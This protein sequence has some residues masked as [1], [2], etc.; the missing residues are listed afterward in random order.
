MAR[1]PLDTAQPTYGKTVGRAVIK[2]FIHDYLHS[3]E[4]GFR[5]MYTQAGFDDMVARLKSEHEYSIYLS[6]V[7]L[8]NGLVEE[9]VRAQAYSQQAQ[10]GMLHLQVMIDE[11]RRR[12]VQQGLL[13]GQA[14]PPAV[15]EGLDGLFLSLEAASADPAVSAEVR[16]YYDNLL[17][18]A[19]RGLQ[20]YNAL[21][22]LLEEAFR[23]SELHFLSLDLS[24]MVREIDAFNA[25][26]HTT[27]GLLAGDETAVRQKTAL[28]DALFV[29]VSLDDARPS[30]AV[31][32]DARAAL[33]EDGARSGGFVQQLLLRLLEAAP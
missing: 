7:A 24:F 15:Q 4:P 26:L 2:S 10:H 19:L 11:V 9:L 31:L 16:G 28:L 1:S 20:A 6:Y 21:I 8:H 14:L 5:P 25:T 29:P 12:E 18:P 17:L 33:S 23:F 13:Q 22:A 27:R 32:D 3:R 30:Q